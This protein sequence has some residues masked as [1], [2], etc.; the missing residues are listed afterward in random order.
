MKL[1]TNILTEKHF[2]RTF[3][4]TDKTFLAYKTKKFPENL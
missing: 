4:R 2:D 3:W 1:N